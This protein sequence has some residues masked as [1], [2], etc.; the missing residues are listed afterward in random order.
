MPLT[1]AR[2]DQD[3]IQR[4]GFDEPR[5]DA[6]RAPNYSSILAISAWGPLRRQCCPRRSQTCDRWSFEHSDSTPGDQE[7]DAGGSLAGDRALACCSKE[8]GRSARKRFLRFRLAYFSPIQRII[9]RERSNQNETPPRSRI[10]QRCCLTQCKLV[11]KLSRQRVAH[12]FLCL[13]DT[14]GSFDLATG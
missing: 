9:Q 5:A 11:T 10:A 4:S 8:T 3:A 13:L 6:Q 7:R 1:A 12:P 2:S 14:C